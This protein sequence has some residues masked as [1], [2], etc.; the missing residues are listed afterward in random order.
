VRLS[1]AISQD[2]VYARLATFSVGLIP[3]KRC[4]ITAYVDPVKYYEYRAMGLPVLSSAFGEMQHKQNDLGIFFFEHLLQEVSKDLTHILQAQSHS[5][6]A[7]NF[8]HANAW[9]QRFEVL[10]ETLTS[11]F[12]ERA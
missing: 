1:P 5:Q 4:E 3:F 10:A 8:S 6:E 11:A 9:P 12:K 7:L 2:Q